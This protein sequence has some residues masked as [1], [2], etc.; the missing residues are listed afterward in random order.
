MDKKDEQDVWAVLRHSS[1]GDNWK[2][3]GYSDWD[4]GHFTVTFVTLRDNEPHGLGIAHPLD[5]LTISAQYNASEGK[6]Y[7]FDCYVDGRRVT[8]EFAK[9]AVKTLQSIDRAYHK[10]TDE[11]G[12]PQTFGAYVLYM[13]KAVKVK[14]ILRDAKSSRS[15]NT[16][17]E[18]RK[19]KVTDAEWMIA[20]AL[21][22]ILEKVKGESK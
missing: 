1:P 12:Y 10:I 20:E 13:L 16:P 2:G 5:N 9:S 21:Q 6:P 19:Y 8:L 7:G 14:G 11:W 15:W 18:W 17:G 22:P 3:N 4:Y